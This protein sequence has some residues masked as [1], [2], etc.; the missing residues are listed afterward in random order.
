MSI[1][2]SPQCQRASDEG[3]LILTADT[4]NYMDATSGSDVTAAIDYDYDPFFLDMAIPGWGSIVSLPI[5]ASVT[6][7]MEA[8]RAS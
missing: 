7:R 4:A 8:G 1:S 2:E 5:N 3:A 6:M